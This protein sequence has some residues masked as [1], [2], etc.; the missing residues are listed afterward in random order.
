MGYRG[1]IGVLQGH[2]G[3][4]YMRSCRKEGSMSNNHRK[5]EERQTLED[6]TM[7]VSVATHVH[8]TRRPPHPTI[9]AIACKCAADVLN[10][11]M[12]QFRVA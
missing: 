9:N 11:K 1:Y 8:D 6:N 10:I 3:L 7:T 5:L 2:I 12:R 4:A